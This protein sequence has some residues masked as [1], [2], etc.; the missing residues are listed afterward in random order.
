M[1]TPPNIQDSSKDERINFVR[2]QWQCLNHCPSCGK[3]YFLKGRDA[4]DL[5]AEYIKGNKS[6]IDVTKELRQAL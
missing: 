5:Y 1:D 3:C 4:E 6:Y 2:K